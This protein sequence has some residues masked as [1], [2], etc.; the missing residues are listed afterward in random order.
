MDFMLG[1][2]IVIGIIALIF[3]S[4][5]NNSTN[6][7]NSNTNN[8]KVIFKN[9]NQPIKNKT[10]INACYV[11]NEVFSFELKG[12]FY[13][14]YKSIGNFYGYAKNTYNAH[15]KYSVGIFV[16][17]KLAG[18]T[19][20]GNYRLH[21]TLNK[22][23]NNNLLCWGSIGYDDY[24]NSYFGQVYIPIG[25]TPQEIENTEIALKL[26]P[27][28]NF[29]FKKENISI[30]EYFELLDND[31]KIY[32]LITNLK[33]LNTINYS[34]NRNILPQLSKKLEE[35]KDWINLIKL[36]N[37]PN[38]INDLSLKYKNSTLKRIELAKS[39]TQ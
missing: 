10:D 28:Q 18:H 16:N 34:F 6:N 26:I 4:K 20:K 25:F 11:K 31:N 12:V 17:N 35:E 2:V 1:F 8:T 24:H 23:H 3:K 9:N 13:N 19:P 14:D 37:Y 5:N 21:N 15:D 7:N 32:K 36:E 33:I 38:I 27:R 39:I 29:L 22:F 30:T